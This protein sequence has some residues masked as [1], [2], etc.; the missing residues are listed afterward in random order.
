MDQ[1]RDWTPI[2]ALVLAGLALFIAL[3]GPRGYGSDEVRTV[4]QP[5]IVQPAA[6]SGGAP[7]PQVIVPSAPPEAEHTWGA[8]RG[9]WPPCPLFPL[10]FL[11]GLAF[12]AY[13][14]LG[15]RGYGWGGPGG[16]G[17]PW[18]GPGPQGSQG[19][20]NAPH[21]QPYQQYPP[22]Y[23]QGQQPQ[24]GQ[25]YG[26]YPQ[27][28]QPQQGQPTHSTQADDAHGDITRPEGDGK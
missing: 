16:Y 9:G 27:G 25:P 6:P 22:Q 12:I 15:R 20:P 21:Q 18:G 1:N 11:A 17:R 8:W 24:Q 3:S 23:G 13:K 28:Q 7:A 2:A 19:P 14:V 4:P 10:I 26:G 5:I